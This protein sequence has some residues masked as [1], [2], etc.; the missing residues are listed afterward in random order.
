MQGKVNKDEWVEMFREIGLTD[1][2]MMKW[3][4]IFEKKHPEEH[5]D[6]LAW[7]G[8][9]EYERADIRARSK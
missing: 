3:H 5:E 2:D 7:L 1:D 8:I 9:S 4:R 6:F